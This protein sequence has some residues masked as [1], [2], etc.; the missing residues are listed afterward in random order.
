MRPQLVIDHL[1]R[2]VS[3]LL[4]CDLESWRQADY[5]VD[6]VVL[7]ATL[8]TGE[9]I[10]IKAGSEA[11]VDAFVLAQLWNRGMKVPEPIADAPLRDQPE[12]G[13]VLV[14]HAAE[15]TLLTDNGDKQ[16]QYL[17]PLIMEM[18]QVH[19]SLT[20]EIAGPVL[21]VESGVQANSWREYLLSIVTGSNSEFQWANLLRHPAIDQGALTKALT[22]LELQTRKVEV[23]PPYALLHG[24]LNP[25]NVFVDN[26]EIR[27]I[28]D[29]SYARY[30]D[31]L[32]DFARLRMTPLVQSRP[33]ALAAY[34]QHVTHS[35]DDVVREQ[36]Y[37]LI[38]LL[39]YVNWYFL[40]GEITSAQTQLTRLSS[41]LTGS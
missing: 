18:Q 5:G 6:H 32:Y 29:W 8:S 41:A 25:A 1:L 19:Q 36:L 9:Q 17:V 34:R 35:S 15:G 22:S 28:I 10:V 38:N 26:G 14:M 16:D 37:Y 12:P 27:S 40:D 13:T 39:E 31:P 4:A 11:N 2:Q 24:D 30:G 23:A 7:M 3:A 33:E 21:A 20:A